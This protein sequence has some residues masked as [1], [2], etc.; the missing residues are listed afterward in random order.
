MVFKGKK[1]AILGYG[2]NN[3]GLVPFLQKQGAIITICDKN[4]Q[5]TKEFSDITYQLGANYLD[6]LTNFDIMFRTPGLPYLSDRIQQAKQAG[7]TITSQTQLFMETCQ[8]K[9]IGITGTKG[10]GTTA[11]LINTILTMAKGNGEIKGQIFLAG[12]IGL[13]PMTF[14]EKVTANDWVILELSSFQLQDITKSPHIAVVLNTTSDHLDHHQNV[15]EYHD[16]KKNLV[17]YQTPDDFVVVYHD[18]PVTMSFLDE[19][20]ADPY[21]FSRLHPVSLGSFV[22]DDRVVLRLPDVDDQTALTIDDI[23]LVGSYNLENITAAVVTGA[24]AQ[25]S[26]ESIRAGVKDFTGLSHR[27]QFVAQKQG[28]RYYDDSKATTPDSTIA[29]IQSFKEPVTLIIG[30]SSKGA[31]FSDLVQTIKD[32]SVE[33]VICI[34]QEG[35]RLQQLLQEGGA[36]QSL[37]EGAKTM[38]E[39]VAQ[40]AKATKSGDIVLLSPAAA[41]FDMFKNAEDRGDQFQAAVKN[42]G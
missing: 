4:E 29:A 6:N 21:F 34:G 19:T 2:V 27:L 26:V 36:S 31:D 25:V 35:A 24:L 22:E 41:S 37:I 33:T 13:S 12:N 15:E 11:S 3:A 28:V 5:L 20:H 42:L 9:V 7:V 38:S 16:A 18:S 30:G 23:N 10:K 14:V 39:I 40:A 17:R 32:S 8:A 1:V